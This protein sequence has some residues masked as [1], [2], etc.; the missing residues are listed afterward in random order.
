MWIE[1][2]KKAKVHTFITKIKRVD[3]GLVGTRDV[4]PSLRWQAFKSTQKKK[5]KRKH[6]ES[7]CQDGGK[8]GFIPLLTELWAESNFACD[9]W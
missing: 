4:L 6:K 7:E 2:I 3:K 8:D 9:W 5:A 1:P